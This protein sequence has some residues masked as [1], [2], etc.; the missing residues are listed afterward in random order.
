MQPIISY[1]MKHYLTIILFTVFSFAFGQQNN[2]SEELMES[3]KADVWIPF[4]EAYAELNSEKL[5]SIH[6]NDIFRVTTDNNIVKSGQSYLDEFG[7][8]L[9]H[10]KKN[11][12]ELEIAFVVLTTATND[13][14]DLAYQTGYYEFSSKNENEPNI[15]V[16][17]YGHFSV[18]LRKKNG[19]WK[20]FLDSDKRVDIT[21]EVFK[22]QDIVYRLGK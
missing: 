10:V 20:L 21:K 13:S 7:G 4:M 1:A 9:D 2:I 3:I 19:S 5:K 8:F 14:Q 18:G 15:T 6:A 16:K 22:S 12:G 17:G 11:K